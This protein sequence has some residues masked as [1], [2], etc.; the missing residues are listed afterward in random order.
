MSKRNK[1]QLEIMPELQFEFFNELEIYR[2]IATSLFVW[3][4]LPDED[5]YNK[6]YSN[7]VEQWL[8]DYPLV[9]AFDTKDYGLLI[10]PASYSKLNIYYQPTDAKPV[11]SAYNNKIIEFDANKTVLCFD[12]NTRSYFWDNIY[13]YVFKLV[14]I[15]HTI[16]MVCNQLRLPYIVQAEKSQVATLNKVFTDLQLGKHQI[17]THKGVNLNELITKMDFN[18]DSGHISILWEA[19]YKLKAEMLII[20]GIPFYPPSISSKKANLIKDEVNKDDI[21]TS[22]MSNLRLQK[23]M[24]FC[25]Q[26]NEVFAPE[27]PL[28]VRLRYPI[29]LVE[30]LGEESAALLDKVNNNTEGDDNND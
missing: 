23:R 27:K 20:L 16:N 4:N 22:A 2:N 3:D 1:P 17:F 25:K 24:E 30:D 6:L 7:I 18:V 8:L 15:R 28:E 14:N 10:L 9:G 21:I 5:F 12:N 11:R 19:Y 13:A 29:N 26:Y